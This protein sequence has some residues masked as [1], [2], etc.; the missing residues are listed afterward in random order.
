MFC[1]FW[2]LGLLSESFSISHEFGAK[3][4]FLLGN[5]IKCSIIPKCDSKPT[6]K[7]NSSPNSRRSRVNIYGLLLLLLVV[8]SVLPI[9][10]EFLCTKFVSKYEEF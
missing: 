10:V 2:T 7:L 8:G 3:R 9:T 5:F 6:S 1:F 4:E